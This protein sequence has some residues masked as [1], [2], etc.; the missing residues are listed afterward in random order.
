MEKTIR[1][2]TYRAERYEHLVLTF[3]TVFSENGFL[4]VIVYGIFKSDTKLAEYDIISFE[5]AMCEIISTAE[6][7]IIS[8]T[9]ADE[10]SKKKQVGWKCFLYEEDEELVVCFK[11]L[12]EFSNTNNSLNIAFGIYDIKT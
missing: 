9:V 3:M 5:D 1:R 10:K 2:A 7:P 12:M 8:A 11:K 6:N 4:V